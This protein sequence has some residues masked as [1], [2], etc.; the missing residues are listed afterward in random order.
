MPPPAPTP[1]EQAVQPLPQPPP[2]PT[3]SSLPLV[4]QPNISGSY[5]GRASAI[6]DTTQLASFSDGGFVPAA[7]PVLGE[8]FFDAGERATVQGTGS[9]INLVGSTTVAG[10]TAKASM[11]VVAADQTSSTGIVQV[12]QAIVAYQRLIVGVSDTAFADPGSVVPTLDL[13]GPNAIATT[14]SASGKGAQGRISYLFGPALTPEPGFIGDISVEQ[15]TPEIGNVPV[16][17]NTSFAHVPDLILTLKYGDGEMT[18]PQ[19]A[20]YEEYWHLQLGTVFRDLSFETATKSIDT[21]AFGWG[22]QLSGFCEV[23]IQRECAPEDAVGFCVIG[24]DG[25]GHYINDLHTPGVGMGNDAIVNGSQLEALPVI[26]Y[27]VGYLRNWSD[28][29]QST[30]GFSRVNLSSAPGT[31]FDCISSRRLC[32]R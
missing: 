8:K 2:S 12:P 13:A 25:I 9:A 27:Y 7:I 24:G 18:G 31:A 20:S 6:F 26:T 4:N 1:P 29:L 3:S 17:T 28:S 14:E 32:G 30:F 11:T 19:N 16:A 15:P 10:S 21:S 22:I 23:P 5:V